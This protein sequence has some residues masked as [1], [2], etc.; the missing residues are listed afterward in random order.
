M[1]RVLLADDQDLARSGLR[2]ILELAGIEVVGEA[3]DGAEAV[4]L[5]AELEPDVVFMD[6]RMPGTDGLEATRRIVDAGLPCRVV[7]LTTFDLD[8]HVYDALT[9]GAAGF[10]LK[11][12]SAQQLV[13]AVERTVA[14]EAPMAPQV[15]AR[16]IDRYLERAAPST[17]EPPRLQSLSPREREVLGLIGAGLTN[18]EIAERLVV[19]LATVKTH[20]RSILAKLDARDRVQVVLLAHR[21]GVTGQDALHR[22]ASGR[23]PSSHAEPGTDQRPGVGTI[24]SLRSTARR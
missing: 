23:G 1:T 17:P 5:A 4:A 16:M 24:R 19:S 22:A 3:G 9:A 18:T 8:R 10:L 13:S 11:D 20:V 2:L 12:A 15:L 21:Y 14:G 6:V 7:I